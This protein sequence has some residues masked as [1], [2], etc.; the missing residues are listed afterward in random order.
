MNCALFNNVHHVRFV[1]L[2]EATRDEIETTY[3]AGE[4]RTGG[5]FGEGTTLTRYFGESASLVQYTFRFCDN[6]ILI[7]NEENSL[8]MLIL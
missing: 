5:E 1:F 7:G 2:V 3:V 8:I 6:L 4:D